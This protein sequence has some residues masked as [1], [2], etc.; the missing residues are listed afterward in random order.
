MRDLMIPD[1]KFVESIVQDYDQKAMWNERDETAMIW[2]MIMTG[3]RIDSTM[4]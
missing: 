3:G 1:G 4:G 2:H